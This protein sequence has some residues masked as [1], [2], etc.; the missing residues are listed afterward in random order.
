M[1]GATYEGI[2]NGVPHQ[3]EMRLFG[4]KL[5][6]LY[7][8]QQIGAMRNLLRIS[9]YSLQCKYEYISF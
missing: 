3:K 9:L 8:H 7:T 2:T 5:G 1:T 4:L 6:P